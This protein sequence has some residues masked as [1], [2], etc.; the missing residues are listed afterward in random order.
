MAFQTLHYYAKKNG[1]SDVA[2]RLD[3]PHR[4][5]EKYFSLGK[6]Q[7]TQNPPIVSTD[8]NG[9]PE[10]GRW[11]YGKWVTQVKKTAA[12]REWLGGNGALQPDYVPNTL[13]G[14]IFEATHV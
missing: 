5:P 11:I 12:Y 8:E 13:Q 10:I 1:F 7:C 4:S 3:N 14:R 6:Y 9:L 2:S